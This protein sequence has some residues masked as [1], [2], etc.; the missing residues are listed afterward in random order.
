M[1]IDQPCL[2]VSA[3]GSVGARLNAGRFI[4]VPALEGELFSFDINPRHGLR[5]F[6]DGLTELFG[7]G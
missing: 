6:M 4:A 3:H 5:L 1:D 2:R 7:G